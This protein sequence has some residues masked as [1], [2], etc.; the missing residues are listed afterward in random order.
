MLTC[1]TEKLEN[2]AA[3]IA[4]MISVFTFIYDVS[5][6]QH[7]KLIGQVHHS[8]EDLSALK[9]YF[10]KQTKNRKE[11]ISNLCEA[12][13]GI[14]EIKQL[15]PK[16]MEVAA[17]LETT[18]MRLST[19]HTQLELSQQ[20]LQ[21]ESWFQSFVSEKQQADMNKIADKF[22]YLLKIAEKP[23]VKALQTILNTCTKTNLTN[24]IQKINDYGNME[25]DLIKYIYDNYDNET[26]L[27]TDTFK[28]VFSNSLKIVKSTVACRITESKTLPLKETGKQITLNS[29][30]VSVFI[31]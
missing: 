30:T 6:D 29:N 21:N 22:I 9:A 28:F 31:S 13:R 18:H 25:P 7:K 1:F 26:D 10:V 2:T 8:E 17:S 15:E 27:V 20:D 23:N 19:Y 5:N 3:D 24:N 11:P 16:C 12:I 14:K 4:E